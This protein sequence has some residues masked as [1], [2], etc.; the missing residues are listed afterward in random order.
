M[1]EID[2]EAVAQNYQKENEQLRMKMLNKRNINI[3][4]DISSAIKWVEE[5]Y[6][7]VIVCALVFSYAVSACI[8]IYK[9]RRYR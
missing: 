7:F 4:L 9:A 8:D 6:L 1:S 3:D 5:H 2:W